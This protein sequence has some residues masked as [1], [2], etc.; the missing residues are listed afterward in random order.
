[1][2]G[3]GG[4]DPRRLDRDDS[5][6][7]TDHPDTDPA[8]PVDPAPWPDRLRLPELRLLD[9]RRPGAAL[10]AAYQKRR[11]DPGPTDPQPDDRDLGPTARCPLCH[12]RIRVELVDVEIGHV[13]HGVHCGWGHEFGSADLP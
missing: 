9:H 13:W 11:G 7:P 6:E 4:P 3:D 10:L 12:E 5:T 2:R 8:L 1:M